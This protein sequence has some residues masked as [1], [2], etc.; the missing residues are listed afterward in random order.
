MLGAAGVV[1]TAG[2]IAAFNVVDRIADSTGIPLDDNGTKE[3]REAV[4]KEVGL[5][6]F[7]RQADMAYAEALPYL[8]DMLMRCLGT[9]DAQ[10]GLAAF[11]QKRKPVWTGR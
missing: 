11:L 1:D 9:A 3:F 8:Q 6:A 7:H 5:E 4:G 10:E 2:V